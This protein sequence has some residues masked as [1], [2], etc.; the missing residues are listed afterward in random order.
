[1]DYGTLKLIHVSAVALSFCG[2]VARG[3]GSLREASWVRTRTARTL[4]HLVDTVLLLSALA[5]LWIIRLSPWAMPWLR[6]KLIGLVVYIVLGILALRGVRT[7]NPHAG[8][9]LRVTAWIGAL[10]V[11]GYIA[12]VALTKDPLGILHLL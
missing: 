12:S 2:F 11:F 8:K 7:L 9:V 4:P 5:M 6:A 1:M 10:L 3:L